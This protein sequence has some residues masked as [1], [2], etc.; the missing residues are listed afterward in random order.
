M[1]AVV[2]RADGPFAFAAGAERVGQLGQGQDALPGVS[3]D[4]LLPE[5][6]EEAEV[7]LPDR[8]VVA[9]PPELA[10]R[11]VL[12]QN[13]SRWA[14]F[15]R[16]LQVAEESLGLPRVGA[17]P[18]PR[19]PA[20]PAVPDDPVAGHPPLDAGQEQAANIQREPLLL[21]DRPAA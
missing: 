6:A 13:Q 11:A 8:L 4:L 10:H 5:P 3:L 19:G 17:Q 9:P 2:G 14:G 21:P 7:V 16:L 15:P 12:I 1:V 18:D 20:L